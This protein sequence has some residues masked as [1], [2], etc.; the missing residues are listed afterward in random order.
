MTADNCI[1]LVDTLVPNA[2]PLTLKQRWLAELEGE[3]L[4]NVKKHEPEAL[5]FRGEESETLELSVPFPFDRVYWMFLAA[6]VDFFNGDISRY[7]ETAAL[8][9]NALE[10]YAKWYKREGRC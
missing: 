5:T 7:E 6:M 9:D 3:I 2:V 1:A 10:S 8:A 4:V